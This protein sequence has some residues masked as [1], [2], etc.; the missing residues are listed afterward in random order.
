VDIQLLVVRFTIAV[1]EA[2]GLALRTLV[3][4]EV[5]LQAEPEGQQGV[6]PVVMV[7]QIQAQVME[8]QVLHTAEVVV[9][10]FH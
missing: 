3:V 5:T 2:A 4:M 6:A 8:P 1:E 10:Q 7:E 9:V